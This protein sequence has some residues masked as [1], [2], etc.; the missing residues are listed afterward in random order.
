MV[1]ETKLCSPCLLEIMGKRV[2]VVGRVSVKK[3]THTA[4][5]INLTDQYK[6]SHTLPL[7]D[8]CQQFFFHLPASDTHTHTQ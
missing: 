6:L 8:D 4:Q 5:I 3:K 7:F 2:R 1:A